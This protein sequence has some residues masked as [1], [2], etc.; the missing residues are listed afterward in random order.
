[1]YNHAGTIIFK[2]NTSKM[3]T[4]D[5]YNNYW[6]ELRGAQVLRKGFSSPQQNQ[7]LSIGQ[8]CW[9]LSA[10]VIKYPDKN[11]LGEK[12][13]IL[14]TPPAWMQSLVAVGAFQLQLCSQQRELHNP[15]SPPERSTSSSKLHFLKLLQSSQT[16]PQ[17]EWGQGSNT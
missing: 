13:F 5:S 15:Q 17:Q 8:L 12:G 4:L 3:L 2:I 6:K 1:M 10:A 14:L 7:P 11:S 16:A 9:P